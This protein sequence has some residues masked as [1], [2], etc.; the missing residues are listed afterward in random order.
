EEIFELGE[1]VGGVERQIDRARA[2]CR[3][4]E[5]QRLRRFLDLHRDAVAG[6]DPAQHQDVGDAAGPRDRVAI[7]QPP[8][9]SELQERL[10]GSGNMRAQQIEE[11]STHV[12]CRRYFMRH[13]Y[14]LSRNAP[15]V[16]LAWNS[17][18]KPRRELS[19]QAA[20]PGREFD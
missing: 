18:T 1:C 14:D 11:I 15:N 19:E 20:L 8:A 16:W 9:I 13:A 6:L 10:L 7:A 17:P 5:D 12:G 4:V 2:Q 3:E